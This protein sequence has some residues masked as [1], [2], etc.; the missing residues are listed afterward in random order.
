VASQVEISKLA[1]AH[2]ADAARVNSITPPD[3]TMQAQH[4]AT[5]YP[6]ARDKCLEAYAWP[7]ATK[8][9]ELTQS[10]VTAPDGEWAYV[11]NLPSDYIAA[12]KVVFP[13]AQEDAPGQPFSIRSDQ[14][15]LDILLFTNVEDA[16][17]HYTF[18]EEESGRYSPLF[19]TALSYLLGSYLA[20][21]IVKGR[22][23]LQL[24]QGLQELFDSEIAKAA[25]SM[26]N[27]TGRSGTQYSLH[28]PVWV[29]DR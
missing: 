20:G 8:R 11:Y 21:P 13:G 19:V 16:I 2:I 1:L 24:K 25:A 4:C 3:N 26:L 29:R 28:T 7:F 17:L 22:A 6:I 18:R 15:E 12:H 9:I 5:F 23:G 10:I 14:T 27:S